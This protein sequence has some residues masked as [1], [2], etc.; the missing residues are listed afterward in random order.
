[1]C[2]ALTYISSFEAEHC[3]YKFFCLKMEEN[4]IISEADSSVWGLLANLCFVCLLVPISL[5]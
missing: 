1:M 3:S 2:F 5:L 4:E